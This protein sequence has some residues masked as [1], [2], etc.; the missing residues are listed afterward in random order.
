SN[1]KPVTTR[2]D[3][4]VDFN[5]GTSAP[6]GTALSHADNY[7]VKWVGFV[8]PQYSETYTFYT[9]TDDGVR[10]WVDNV[11]VV[12]KWREQTATEWSGTVKLQADKLYQVRLEYFNRT[13]TGASAHLSW[14]SASQAKQVVP[15]S[16]L[17]FT[18]VSP[19]FSGLNIH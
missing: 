7:S 13:S 9:S 19:T 18:D 15:S 6:S 2:L 14:S 5:W 4:T 10:L 1:L 16:R 3:A 11:L 8:K 17:F 12:D